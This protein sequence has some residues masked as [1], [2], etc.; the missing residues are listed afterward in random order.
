MSL[1]RCSCSAALAGRADD[2]LIYQ[3][4]IVDDSFIFVTSFIKRGY[5]HL[6]IYFYYIKYIYLFVTSQPRRLID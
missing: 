4:W 6:F 2:D 5:L 1:V 3:T